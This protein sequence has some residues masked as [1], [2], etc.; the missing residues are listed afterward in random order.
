MSASAPPPLPDGLN[1]IAVIVPGLTFSLLGAFFGGILLPLLVF[2]FMFSTPTSRAHPVFILNVAIVILGMGLAAINVGQEWSNMVT[3][4]IAIPDSLTLA[5]IALTVISPLVIDSVLI[6]RYIAFYPRRS[7][8]LSTYAKILAFPV[9]VKT[10]RLVCDTIFLVHLGSTDGNGS[11]TLLAAKTW[12]RNPYLVSE[13]SLQ[14]AD[15]VY[16]TS[17]FF[18]KLRTYYKGSQTTFII[19]NQSLLSRI[20]GLFVIALSNFVFPLFLNVT[21]MIMIT[22]DTDYAR[23]AEVLMA[24]MYVSIFGVLFAT[25][26]ASGNAWGR[27]NSKQDQSAMET[28]FSDRPGYISSGNEIRFA[29]GTAASTTQA[30]RGT[31]P[32]KHYLAMGVRGNQTAASDTST[33]IHIQQT[34]ISDVKGDYEP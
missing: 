21:Q 31:L 28:T 16:A 32:P 6:F 11:I 2:L 22:R 4:T 27:N 7:T 23:G 20:R 34:T 33:A 12:F 10:G 5:N 29:K 15:N 9:I 1:Y 18:W 19:R 25:V 24:N 17:F 13:W 3:P 30:S 8:P 14:I 26:W